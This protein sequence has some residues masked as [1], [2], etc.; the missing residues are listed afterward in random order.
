MKSNASACHSRHDFAHTLHSL[1]H[2]K[3]PRFPESSR[4]SPTSQLLHTVVPL[5]ETLLPH[6]IALAVRNGTPPRRTSQ[7]WTQGPGLQRCERVPLTCG[8][9]IW[10]EV[11]AGEGLENEEG[12]SAWLLPSES[13]SRVGPVDRPYSGS[14]VGQQ[15]PQTCLCAGQGFLWGLT[16]PVT[17]GPTHPPG[18]AEP[19]SYY[20]L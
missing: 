17:S 16:S 11:R 20:H 4:L 3:E 14:G 8:F 9:R 10:V 18:V 7:A 12:L 19:I 15:A 6:S 1:R 5:P 13:V 2:K